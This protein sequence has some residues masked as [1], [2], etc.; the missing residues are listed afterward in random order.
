MLL[1]SLKLIEHFYLFFLITIEFKYISPI[2]KVDSKQAFNHRFLATSK[3][4]TH[5]DKNKNI[6]IADEYNLSYSK[7]LHA[8]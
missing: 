2:H 8:R 5:D 1:T 3:L 6:G 4:P 7:K